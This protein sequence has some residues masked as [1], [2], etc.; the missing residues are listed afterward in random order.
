MHRTARWTLLLT[1]L[2]GCALTDWTASP[3][4][5]KAGPAFTV[6]ARSGPWSDPKTW[7]GGKVP[8]AGARVQVKPGHTV[9]YDVADGPAIR[10]IH[11]AGILTFA[12]DR[13]TRLEVGL[14]AI[15]P[16]ADP[17][18]EDGFSCDAH[19]PEVAFGEA[20]PALEVGT[21]DQPL[22]PKYTATIRLKYFEGQNQ[23]SCPAIV[24]CG[25]RL[26]LHGAP[27]SRTWLRLGADA[28]KGDGVVVLA[29]KV[30]GWK[31]GD[32]V[33]VTA[34]HREGH[35]RTGRPGAKGATE[36]FTEVRTVKDFDGLRLTLDAPLTYDHTGSG[37]YRAA[38]A[39]LSRNIVVES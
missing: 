16:G 31:V 15:Q 14:I 35:L 33:I 37:E 11:V 24:C 39:N 32:R 18:S 23:D 6:S 34:A 1:L 3:A 28:H 8:G 12:R 27:L 22:D 4:A 25:G 7:E 5:Q 30:T 2:A 20:P 21:P 17:A 29:E 9:T 38:V 13:S 26:D 19:Y 10:F 36:T